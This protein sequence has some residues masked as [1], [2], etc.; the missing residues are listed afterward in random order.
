MEQLWVISTLDNVSKIWNAP[1]SWY[2]L[3]NRWTPSDSH[4]AESLIVKV[5]LK[6]GEKVVH[7]F[8]S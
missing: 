5:T 7:G 6:P 1:A 2:E 3:K 8:V 4:A